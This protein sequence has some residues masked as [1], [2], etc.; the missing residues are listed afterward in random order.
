MK[1]LT[2]KMLA[3]AIVLATVAVGEIA[4]KRIVVP[5]MYMFGFAASFN[6]TIVHF[7]DVQEVEAAW[8]DSKSDFLLGRESY[9]LQLK[10]YLGRKENLPYRT[11]TIVYHLDREKLEKKYVKMKKLYTHSKDGKPHFD[12]RYLNASD[13]RFEAV[14]MRQEMEEVE[15]EVSE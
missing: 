4:A 13:F 14:D 11:C 15:P 9:S 6:D 8:V 5:K 7:T 2:Y 3:I 1:H 10:Q 12:V